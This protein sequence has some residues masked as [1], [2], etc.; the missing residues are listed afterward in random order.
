MAAPTTPG[1]FTSPTTAQI[2]DN[3]ITVSWGAST[4]ADGDPITYRLFRDD[5]TE[6]VAYTIT[7]NG[8]GTWT[9][10]AVPDVIVV[11]GQNLFTAPDTQA[12]YLEANTYVVNN[13]TSTGEMLGTTTGTS[14]VVDTSLWTDTTVARFRVE[15]YA[16]NEWSAYRYS[17]YF[18]IDH[19]KLFRIGAN[20][21]DAVYVGSVPVDAIYVGTVQVW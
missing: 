12:L 2:V 3:T 4:D 1:V 15:A 6:P 18:T 11:D 7:D 14:M 9:A 21:T 5:G 19:P 16:N 8:D 20:Q 17:P 13:T 10:S